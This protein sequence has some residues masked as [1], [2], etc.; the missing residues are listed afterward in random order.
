MRPVK[1]NPLSK[2][3]LGAIHLVSATLKVENAMQFFGEISFPKKK[4]GPFLLF[5]LS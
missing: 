4:F 1:E 5:R 2:K 3:K